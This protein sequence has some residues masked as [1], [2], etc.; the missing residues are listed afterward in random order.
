MKTRTKTFPIENKYKRDNVWSAVIWSSFS[1]ASI[2][3][4]RT[5][6]LQRSYEV[7]DLLTDDL[8][9]GELILSTDDTDMGYDEKYLKFWIFYIRIPNNLKF[10]VILSKNLRELKK[11][12]K[13]THNTQSSLKI[14]AAVSEY[15]IYRYVVRCEGTFHLSTVFV[16]C[17]NATMKE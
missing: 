16:V 2:T 6:Y 5:P 12:M 11:K 14:E 7:V 15:A 1:V 13:H 4:I 8:N 3:I 17:C 10:G 9:I